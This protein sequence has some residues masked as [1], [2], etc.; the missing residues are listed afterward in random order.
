MDVYAAARASDTTAFDAHVGIRCVL[1][2]VDPTVNYR[3]VDSEDVNNGTAGAVNLFIAIDVEV[4]MRGV[5]GIEPDGASC[6]ALRI[7]D[8]AV[9]GGA[10][11]GDVDIHR[12][13][14]AGKRLDAGGFEVQ[15]V[16]VGRVE[17]NRR[18]RNSGQGDAAGTGGGAS[19]IAERAPTNVERERAS[20]VAGFE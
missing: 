2:V 15:E 19:G 6:A 7:E 1:I 20:V 11:V 12:R 18:A 3:I 9:P 16:A 13:G 4:Q 8:V 14:V 5:L 17:V 10:A